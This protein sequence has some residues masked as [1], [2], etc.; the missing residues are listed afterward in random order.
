M[1]PWCIPHC[2]LWQ[3]A[4]L[5]T[6]FAAIA[7]AGILGWR[8]I[9]HSGMRLVR[10]LK[11]NEDARRLLIQEWQVRMEKSCPTCSASATSW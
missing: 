7:M 8:L 9:K 6:Q 11:K 10:L 2:L 4:G 1:L 5:V 3:G